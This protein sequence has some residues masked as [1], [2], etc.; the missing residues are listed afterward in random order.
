MQGSYFALMR[1][2]LIKDARSRGFKVVDLEPVFIADYDLHHERFENPT[3]NHW[4]EHGHAV[5]AAAV[6]NALKEW[7]PLAKVK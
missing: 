6:L 2:Q 3:D 4:N 5:V 1:T 7:P